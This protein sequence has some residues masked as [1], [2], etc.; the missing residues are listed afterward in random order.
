M[1]ASIDV[2]KYYFGMSAAIYGSVDMMNDK[3]QT[4]S[5]I[6]KRRRTTHIGPPSKLV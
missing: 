6:F 1:I 2:I 4:W 3:A 5:S